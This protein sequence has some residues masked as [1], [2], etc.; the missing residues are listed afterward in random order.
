MLRPRERSLLELLLLNPGITFNRECIVSLIWGLSDV[1]LRTVDVT[2]S[3]IREVFS[4]RAMRNPIRGVTGR[5]YQISDYE[6]EQIML[7]LRRETL[8]LM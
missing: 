5:G 3:R 8:H 1:D 7:V 2:V 4:Q 6:V